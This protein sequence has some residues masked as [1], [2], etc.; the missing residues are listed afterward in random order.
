MTEPA[1]DGAALLRLARA[2]VETWV[3]EGRSPDDALLGALAHQAPAGV[4]VSLKQQHN[5]RGCIGSVTS[6]TGDL[7]HEVVR[8]AIQAAVADPRFAPVAADE[9]DSL[10][11]SIDILSPPEPVESASDLQPRTYG[12]MVV[13]GARRGLLLP[14]LE[15]VDDAATQLAIAQLKGGIQREEPQQLYR[16][17]VQRFAEA[18]AR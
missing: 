13:A 7:G 8:S 5:L 16:F 2:A 12:V 4:F 3:R 15:G 6:S 18:A 1:Y 10:A 9:L 11:Y 17:Q 14:D